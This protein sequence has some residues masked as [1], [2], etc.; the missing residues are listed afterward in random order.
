MI[1]KIQLF[2]A[3][4]GTN[5][6]EVD[7][8]ETAT[9]CR[10]SALLISFVLATFSMALSDFY[11]HSANSLSSCLSTTT[12][13]NHTFQIR[14]FLDHWL[15]VEH[16]KLSHLDTFGAFMRFANALRSCVSHQTHLDCVVEEM[17]SLENLFVRLCWPAMKANPFSSH[18]VNRMLF[19]VD[20]TFAIDL[21]LDFGVQFD[22]LGGGL[23]EEWNHERTE[24][25]DL[26]ITEH[27]ILLVG[28]LAG[29]E[30][31]VFRNGSFN[32][33]DEISFWLIFFGF[34]CSNKRGCVEYV[35]N[36]H[37]EGFG[38]YSNRFE[39]CVDEKFLSFGDN[40]GCFV[41]FL[42]GLPPIAEGVFI[43]LIRPELFEFGAIDETC[44]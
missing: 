23:F 22:G 15:G 42:L 32:Q 35:W 34:G 19:L 16:S 37:C 31:V 8:D 43:F 28:N 39:N 21:L 38:V 25:N 10:R 14:R 20:F 1:R 3:F 18:W 13:T 24:T 5:Q 7:V 41:L 9:S 36:V 27:E 26:E 17:A 30:I 40:L 6:D 44:C 12:S 29:S 4:D 2:V 11:D 33:R